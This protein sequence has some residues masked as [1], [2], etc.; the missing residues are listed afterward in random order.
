MA[1]TS[2]LMLSLSQGRL[3]ELS[4]EEL[5]L[6]ILEQTPQLKVAVHLDQS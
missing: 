6:T 2:S 1:A 5:G 3:Q 4:A